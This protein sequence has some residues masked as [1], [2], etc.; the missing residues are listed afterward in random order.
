MQS[1]PLALRGKYLPHVVSATKLGNGSFAIP[2]GLAN[3][4]VLLA[5]RSSLD[6]SGPLILSILDDVSAVGR[7]FREYEHILKDIFVTIKAANRAAPALV[8]NHRVVQPKPALHR[9][10]SLPEAGSRLAAIDGRV[11]HDPH[12]HAALF[13]HA[14]QFADDCLPF[15]RRPIVQGAVVCAQVVIWRAC[16][17]QVHR[18][19][20]QHIAH[21]LKAI[22]EVQFELA[23]HLDTSWNR[24]GVQVRG[25]PLAGDG[26]EQGWL[27]HEPS[28]SNSR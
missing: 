26:R 14:E 17:S 11:G 10:Q 16:D 18:P 13:G 7:S 8:P 25:L 28:P 22:A 3:T 2:R 6:F 23:I 24:E 19:I 15:L 20:R 27:N 12:D 1:F 9:I 5:K 4:T 21:Q